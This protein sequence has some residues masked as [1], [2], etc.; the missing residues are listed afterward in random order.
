MAMVRH[1]QNQK[2]N[3][4]TTHMNKGS[5]LNSDRALI[6]NLDLLLTVV[7]FCVSLNAFAVLTDNELSRNVGHQMQRLIRTQTADS[8]PAERLKI[9]SHD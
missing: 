7:C 8:Q 6:F 5:T 4:S 9:V 3:F 2:S 1:R